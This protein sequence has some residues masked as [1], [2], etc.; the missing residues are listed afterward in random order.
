M[1]YPVEIKANASE[2]ASAARAF[3]VLDHIPEKKRG[4]GA[5]V[6]LCPHPGQLRENVLQIPVWY[7]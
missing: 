5:V 4:T 3:T 2:T 7:I 6:N 1:L